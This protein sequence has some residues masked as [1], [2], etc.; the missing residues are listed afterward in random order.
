M[1]GRTHDHTHTE[2]YKAMREGRTHDHTHTEH[3]KAMRQGRTHDHTHTLSNIQ[4]MLLSVGSKQY[5]YELGRNED[6]P[7]VEALRTLTA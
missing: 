6:I 2:H 4:T 1:E 7:N 5:L 3:Y